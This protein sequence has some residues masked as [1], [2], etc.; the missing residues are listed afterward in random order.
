M[1]SLPLGIIHPIQIDFSQC[2]ILYAFILSI[3]IMIRKRNW[4]LILVSAICVTGIVAVDF[5]K[6]IKI[7]KEKKI[8]VYDIPSISCIELVDGSDG[9]M[10]VQDLSERQK[11]KIHYHTGNHI[12]K[13]KRLSEIC[14]FSD[15]H[16][17]LPCESKDGILIFSWNE[18]SIAILYQ[19]ININRLKLLPIDFLIISNNVVSLEDLMKR[20]LKIKYMIW[21]SSCRAYQFNDNIPENSSMTHHIRLQGPFIKYLK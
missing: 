19:K 14:L 7:Q 15:I 2:V 1:Q 16:E 4:K 11:S 8:I 3:Y 5:Y 18:K 13:E 6:S 10:L 12:I 17:K 21:D 9:L 20:D